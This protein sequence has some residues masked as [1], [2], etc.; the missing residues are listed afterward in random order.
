MLA[1][2]CW[3][4]VQREKA[5][6]YERAQCEASPQGYHVATQLT[7]LQELSRQEGHLLHPSSQCRG[8][9][10][11]QAESKQFLQSST[12]WA[13]KGFLVLWSQFT[14]YLGTTAKT[15]SWS[16]Q[17]EAVLSDEWDWTGFSCSVL[18]IRTHYTRVKSIRIPLSPH[19]HVT[20]PESIQFICTW[21]CNLKIFQKPD[22]ILRSN[23]K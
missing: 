3:V 16:G 17:K 4:R 1:N 22:W 11:T 12:K 18:L 7:G 21:E 13:F 2:E 6:S 10:L 23:F 8:C 19:K 15:L 9:D 14:R 20:C 5:K